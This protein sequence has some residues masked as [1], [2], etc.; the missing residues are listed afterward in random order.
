MLR[1]RAILVGVFVAL[2]LAGTACRRPAEREEEA[3]AP[4]LVLAEPVR[5][6]TIR[7]TVS[8]TGVVG[9]LPGAEFA[10]VAPHTARIA[11]IAKTVGDPV[12]AGD[13]IVRF[14]FPSLRA[15]LNVRVAAARAADARL[16]HARLLQERVRGLL[17]RG[18]ASQR[19]MDE[20]DR[21]A[22]DA[23][24]AAAEARTQLT[25]AEAQGQQTTILAPFDG[26]ISERQHNP[27]DLVHAENSDP[28]LR[29][30]DPRQVQLIATVAVADL[31][32][33]TTGA[34]ARAVAEGQSLPELLRV[35]SRPDPGPGATTVLVNLAFDSPTTLRPGIQLGVEIDAEQRLNVPLVPP[36]AVLKDGND[37]FVVVAAGGVAQR[38]SVVTGL[39][40]TEHVEIR[41]GLKA[42]EMIVTQGHSNLRDG[43]AISVSEP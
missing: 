28:I 14:E 22:G 9:T 13:V 35:V 34:T 4:V 42:G 32:R 26:V 2:A 16:K 23:E 18:A 41:S 31:T 29:L 20:A 30:I 38:R 10:V 25:A 5:L 8:A 37:S 15:E 43:T 36:I 19:E 27:G 33:F 17:T 39:M 12:K 11:E 21:E 40:D 24:T 6:G 1:A 7:G 3:E